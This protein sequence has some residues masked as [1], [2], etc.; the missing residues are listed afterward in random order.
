MNPVLCV[1]NY[2]YDTLGITAAVLEDRGVDVIKLDAFEP[3]MGWPP[4]E[5]ISGLIVFGGEMNV[6]EVDRHPYLLTE[7]RLMR[8]AVDAGLPVLGIC[9]GAQ[10][11]ART[12]EAPVSQAP[13]PELG[14]KKVTLT[15]AGQRDRLLGGFQTGDFVFQWHRDT[16]D[17]P[18]GADLLAVG[19]EVHNQAFRYGV[20]AWGVQFHF[21]IDQEGVETW[22]RL[23]EPTLEQTFK[24]SAREVRNELRMYLDAQQKRARHLFRDLRRAGQRHAFAADLKITRNRMGPAPVRRCD[25]GWID[26]GRR[27]GGC[28]RRARGM[29]CE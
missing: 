26:L 14:F 27:A 10:M 13:V 21:E 22:L 23:A 12:L 19:D 4:L 6:D 25:E 1:R 8:R 7:R 20:N 28:G 9:L 24:R 5:A 17:L 3:G 11:L 15:G 16:F 29:W 18:S 2:P